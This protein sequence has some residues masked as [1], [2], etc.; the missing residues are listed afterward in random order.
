MRA[1][2][3]LI[4]IQV[5]ASALVAPDFG[6][7]EDDPLALLRVGRGDGGDEI[8]GPQAGEEVLDGAERD[9]FA[10]DLGEALG[11]ALDGR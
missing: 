5:C 7:G 10:G 6:R 2:A 4:F 3:P 1:E 8:V 11:A 9:G